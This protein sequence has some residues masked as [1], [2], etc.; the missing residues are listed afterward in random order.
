M[1]KHK[2]KILFGIIV[3]LI[4]AFLCGRSLLTEEKQIF[5]E[6]LTAEEKII[7]A[8]EIFEEQQKEE[9]IENESNA[10]VEEKTESI[11]VAEPYKVVEN[12][13]QENMTCSLYVRC[14]TVFDNT[15]SIDESK[16]SI[17]PED[18]IIYEC[19]NAELYEGE[20]VFD[21][22]VRELKKN[23][24]HLEFT[25]TP[26][27]NSAYIEGIGNLYEFDCGDLSGWIYRVNGRTP[28]YGCSSYIVENGDIIEFLYS[29]NL[30]VDIGAYK[31]LSGD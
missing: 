4:F 31:N 6:K 16:L 21:V 26:G 1:I 19:K 24:I 9:I 23:R 30:G 28:S 8:Q 13:K 7:A 12:D 25:K 20:S 27:Y 17:I 2:K 22:L 10:E 15:D 18:G 11:P 5:R 14:D 3:V 29:C